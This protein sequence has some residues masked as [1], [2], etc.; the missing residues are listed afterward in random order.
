MAVS[1]HSARF[2]QP[3]YIKSARKYMALCSVIYIRQAVC[4]SAISKIRG[5]NAYRPCGGGQFAG[6]VAKGALRHKKTF[7]DCGRGTA[8]RGRSLLAQVC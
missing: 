1:E 4:D 6:N 8:P 7:L 3:T 5:R 2:C